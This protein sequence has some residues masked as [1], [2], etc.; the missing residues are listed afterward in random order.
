MATI[1]RRGD[2]YRV[3][4]RLGGSSAGAAQ[5]CTFRGPTPEDALEVAELA[6]ELLKARNHDMTRPELYA[7]ILGEDTGA[8]SATPTVKQWVDTWLAELGNRADLDPESIRRYRRDLMLRVVPWMG[9]LRVSDVTPDT[10]KQWVGWV[11]AQRATKGSRN[12]VLTDRTI[13]AQTVRNIFDTLHHCLGAAVPR[14]IAVNPAAR[15]A[16]ARRNPAGLPKVEKHD[17]IYLTHE[18]RE[19]IL[20]HCR[21]LVRSMMLAALATG[22][23]IGELIALR[24][25]DVHLHG[26]G[27][28]VKVRRTLKSGPRRGG[29]RFGPP[30][31]A[32]GRRDITVGVTGSRVLREQVA[33]KRPADHV[34]TAPQGGI[35]DPS[36]LRN[37]YWRQAIAAAQRCAE[38]PPPEPPKPSKGVRR[39]LR[40]DE[41]STCACESRLH[42]TPRFHDLRHSHASDLI[43]AGWSAKKIQVRLGHSNYLLTMNTY[44]HLFNTGDEGEL[45]A[46]D[47]LLLPDRPVT[48]ARR[49]PARSVHRRTARRRVAAR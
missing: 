21:P 30:K 34:F 16:G 10:I 28:V 19:L 25:E 1:Q 44:G 8:S 18:E 29:R 14:W 46:V 37:N 40:V 42:R 11:S 17:A 12:K 39:H 15:P 36:T 24:V 2:A 31:S 33:G 20:A 27:G 35:C 47:T 41:V 4:W 5:S 7:A 43:G 49:E 3:W 6:H 9:H 13:S 38:H 45:H 22:M 32:A 48:A 26:A 23:R